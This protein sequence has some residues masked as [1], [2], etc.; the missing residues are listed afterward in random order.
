MMINVK[1]DQCGKVLKKQSSRLIYKHNFCS[2]QCSQK[3]RRKRINV[4]CD[5]CGK[6]FETFFY[7]KKINT[8]S[9]IGNV[10]VNMT[11]NK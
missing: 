9:A 5:Q 4:K 8:I 3:Y 6:T 10:R 1:C 7:Q 2:N 11:I